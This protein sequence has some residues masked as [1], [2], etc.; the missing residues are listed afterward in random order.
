[1]KRFSLNKKR[2]SQLSINSTKGGAES[3]FPVC[4]ATVDGTV[5]FTVCRPARICFPIP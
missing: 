2:I 5:C 1:M 4:Q 3:V